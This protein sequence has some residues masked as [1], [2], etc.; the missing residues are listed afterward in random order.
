MKKFPA[1]KNKYNRVSIKLAELKP[2]QFLT[3]IT[4]GQPRVRRMN[5]QIIN[6][7]MQITML[8]GLATILFLLIMPILK[9]FRNDSIPSESRSVLEITDSLEASQR[10]TI[11]RAKQLL[12]LSATALIEV[13]AVGKGVG[14]LCHDTPH[15]HQIQSLME[16]GVV[17]TVCEGSLQQIGKKIAHSVEVLPGVHKVADGHHYA[18][19][20]KD[21]GYVDEF[22]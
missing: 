13:V 22:A 1:L 10:L 19:A 4:S 18:E 3:L 17:F 2:I 11:T 9:W 21:S 6:L 15:K 7:I 14:L 5:A 16:K 8:A 20:L 12:E